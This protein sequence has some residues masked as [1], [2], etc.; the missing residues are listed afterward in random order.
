MGGAQQPAPGIVKKAVRL[1]IHFHGHMGAAIQVGMHPPLEADGE[2]TAGMPCIDHIEGYGAPT[3]LQVPAA[4]Q[5]DGLT[6]LQTYPKSMGV[7]ADTG[8][9][10]QAWASSH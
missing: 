9:T 6:H 3:L 8:M 1:V 5:N 7:R 4:A 2:C 10:A